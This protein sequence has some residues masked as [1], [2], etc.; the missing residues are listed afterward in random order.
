MQ[1]K[2]KKQKPNKRSIGSKVV[3]QNSKIILLS[4]D[5]TTKNFLSEFEALSDDAAKVN[6]YFCFF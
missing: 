5:G 3:Y 2:K 6:A 4:I 1:K